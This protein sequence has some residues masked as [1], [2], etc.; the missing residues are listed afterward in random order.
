MR[1]SPGDPLFYHI[2]HLTAASNH[3][4]TKAHLHRHND[5]DDDISDDNDHDNDDNVT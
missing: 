3:T 1:K 2:S 5:D 4:I